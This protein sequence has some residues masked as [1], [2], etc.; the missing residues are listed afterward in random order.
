MTFTESLALLEKLKVAGG[1]THTDHIT[2]H[3]FKSVSLDL[4]AVTR[5]EFSVRVKKH[6][7]QAKNLGTIPCDYGE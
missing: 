2:E 6:P 4:D 7:V 5:I 1:Q 3:E